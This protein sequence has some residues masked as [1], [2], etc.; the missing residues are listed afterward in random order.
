MATTQERGEDATASHNHGTKGQKMNLSI[1]QPGSTGFSRH[2]HRNKKKN[3]EE[4]I[5]RKAL[6]RTAIRQCRRAFYTAVNKESIPISTPILRLIIVTLPSTNN[7]TTPEF[8][9]EKEK[10]VNRKKREQKKITS[11]FIPLRPDDA[12]CPLQATGITIVTY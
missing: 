6:R 11:N 3:K 10:K 4:N 9:T 5:V 12:F 8:L 7:L 1:N 2:R